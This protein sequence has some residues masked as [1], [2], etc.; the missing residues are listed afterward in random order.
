M[1][2]EEFPTIDSKT[3]KT[4]NGTLYLKEPG[5]ALI[6]KPQVNLKSLKPF[7]EGFPGEYK[8]VNYLKDPVKL[9][10]AEALSK[11]SGQT[12]YVSFGEGRTWNRDAQ[13]YFDNIITSGHGSVLEHA[14]FTFLLWGVSRSFTHELVRH[15]AGVGYSQ[16]S[17]RYVSGRVLRFVE[18][19]EYQ[20]DKNLHKLFEDRIDRA[21]K[22][23]SDMANIL[24]SLQEKGSKILSG[25]AKTDLRKK[26]QQVA[27]SVLPNET[28]APVVVTANVRALRHMIN[29]R[30][31]DHA[32]IEIRNVF[33]KI[34]S[35]LKTISPM[36]FKDFKVVKLPDGTKCV[37]TEYPKV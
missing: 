21:Y 1:T 16:V 27:R 6:S 3:F 11:V 37:K 8:F 34:Y 15:R 28:E 23:Y 33:F 4:S 14:N 7:L 26:V 35:I 19:A 36:L 5:I 31:S 30:A 25:E 32:E 29:M 17:Q 2:K 24:Y 9:P 10:P 13:R 12:C 20:K 18:R 22:E